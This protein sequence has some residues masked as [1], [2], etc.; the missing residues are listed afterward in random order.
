MMKDFRKTHAQ[1]EIIGFMIILLIVVVIGVIFLG[2]YLREDKPIVKEDAEIANFLSASARYTSD[3]YKDN[4]PN[5]RTLEDLAVD[6][7]RN[8]LGVTCP[9]SATSCYV[10]NATYDWMLKKLWPAGK[11]RPVKYTHLTLSYGDNSSQVSKFLELKSGNS[12]NC[13]TIKA[14]SNSINLDGGNIEVELE[15]CK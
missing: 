2:I 3:C 4:E 7:Y 15:V 8:T 10:L 14:G 6:C 11:D 5:Y 9:N 13:G 12:S 1:Q